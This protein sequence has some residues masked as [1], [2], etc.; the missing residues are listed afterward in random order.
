MSVRRNDLDTIPFWPQFF[1]HA[2]LWFDKY[3]KKQKSDEEKMK[4]YVEHIRQTGD[5]KEPREYAAFFARWKA[6]LKQMGAQMREA[7]VVARLAAGLG[8]ESV[9]ENG[10][11]LHHTYGVPVIPGSSLKGTA[12]AYAAANLEGP[13]GVSA[14]DAGNKKHGDAFR[15][16]FG[17]QMIPP[18]KEE[19]EKARV[20]IAVF[21]DALPVPDTFGVHNEVM[22]VHHK[23]YYQS[24]EQPPAD[25]DSPT[26]IPFSSVHGRFLIALHAPDAPEWAA[27]GM[28]ILQMALAEFGVGGKTSSGFGRLELI[29]PTLSA[30]ERAISE[31]LQQLS[32]LPNNRVVTELNRFVTRW[33]SQ[34]IPKEA[35]Q[36]V[37]E[38]ILDKVEAA[39][40]TKKS[41]GKAWYQA[42]VDCAENGDC[43]Q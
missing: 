27:S 8:G 4:P 43:P 22:T 29:E 26:P 38:A 40:R 36:S 33:R 15:T 11:T 24:G 19:R 16:L 21:Y 39:G 23:E 3:L 18:G 34:E 32:D 17:G 28:G 12:R 20:G 9:I 42:L 30:E 31:F 14:D 37:A 35:K 6:E 7:D 10:M 13:W 2:G 5:I 1:P 41:Q 25:W